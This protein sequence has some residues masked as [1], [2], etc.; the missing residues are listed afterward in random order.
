MRL[1][2]SRDLG[3]TAEER[4]ENLRRAAEIAK[5]INDAG[6]ICIAAFVA[7]SAWVRQKARELIGADRFFHVHLSTPAEVCRSRDVTGQYQAADKGEI[8]SF[9]G[10]TFEYEIPQDA[11]LL[12]NTQQDSADAIAKLILTR[13]EQFLQ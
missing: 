5:L 10:V 2:I 1:G 8:S 7:P 12:C 11:D 4:S 3:F 9:P 6:Q 13:I